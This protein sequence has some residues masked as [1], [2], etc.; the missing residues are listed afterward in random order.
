MRDTVLVQNRIVRRAIVATGFA[1]AIGVG[2]L[3]SQAYMGSPQAAADTVARHSV[4][5]SRY[6]ENSDGVCTPRPDGSATGIRCKDG[7]FSHAAHRQGACSSHGGID[8]SSGESGG[9]AELGSAALGAGAVG[10]AVIGS[11]VLPALLFA[12]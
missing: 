2:V 9:S 4:C 3:T 5:G 12:S 10:S 11:S 7:S 8:E 1:G 6:Y